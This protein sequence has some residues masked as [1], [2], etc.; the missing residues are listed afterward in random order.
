MRKINI[1]YKISQGKF[2]KY[3]L[4]CVGAG[5]AAEAL[6]KDFDSQLVTAS[7]ECNF[8]YL[9]FHGVFHDDMYVYNEDED[10]NPI[11]NWQYIDLVYDSILEKGMKPFVELGFMPTALGRGEQTVF[12]WKGNVT[13]PKDYEKWYLLVY[14]FVKHLEER[15]KREE[16]LSWYFEVWNEPNHPAFFAGDQAEY[17]K[18]YNVTVSA[19]KSVCAEFRVGGPSTAGN[20]WVPEL[21]KYCSNNNVAIDFVSTHTYGVSGDLDEFGNK[22]F[23]MDKN[24][25]AIIDS[26]KQVYDQVQ[27][28][29]MSNLEIHYTE[30]SASCSSRDP[31][32]DS[33]IQ[34]PYILY[35]LKRLE[36]YVTS[37]SYWTF[38]D[39]FEESGPPPSP[40]HGGFGLFNLQSIKKPSYFVYKFINELGCDELA[41]ND[42]DSWVCRND[43]GIQAL[44]WDYT[45]LPQDA[46][47][48]E[49]FKKDLL[50][51]PIEPAAITVDGLPAGNYVLELFRVGHGINDVYSDYMKMGSPMNLSREQVTELKEKNSGAA[52]VVEKVII[53][54]NQ[55]FIYKLDMRENDMF[56]LK[57]TRSF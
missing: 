4:M 38:T 11:Y 16:V 48:K 19:I 10:G 14:N 53:T 33:Y 13:P 17:F 27:S 39:V 24:K 36:P 42:L 44:I 3:S 52:V 34:A 23:W 26:V 35:N 5:R 57:L 29:E 22:T 1:D 43:Q 18:L 15:Y 8:K 50:A 37:M 25:D 7:D 56:F 6:R 12:W 32:H 47:N 21:I 51:S 30:W 31:I 9:R 49:Y 54:E 55:R 20:A 41:N 45:F 46:P 40:F 2:N 28:S